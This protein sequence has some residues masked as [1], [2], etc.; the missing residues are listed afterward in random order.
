MSA[1]TTRGRF[2]QLA[3]GASNEGMTL[4]SAAPVAD[5]HKVRGSRFTGRFR[6]ICT[7]HVIKWPTSGRGAQGFTL[8][9]TGQAHDCRMRNVT[10][11]ATPSGPRDEVCALTATPRR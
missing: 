9:T 3:L 6:P 8:C 4:A 7:P 1:A 10:V 5:V 11:F 2:D